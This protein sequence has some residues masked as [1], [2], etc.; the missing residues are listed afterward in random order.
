MQLFGL[1]CT[2]A[3]C[4]AALVV[5]VRL[6]LLAR[7]TRELP[8]LMIGCGFLTGAMIG[9]PAGVA[10]G[11]LASESSALAL[12]VAAAGSIGLGLSTVF[13]LV[14]WWKIYHPASRWGPW[15]V[16]IWSVLVAAVVVAELGRSVAELA[17]GANPWDP[18]RLIVEGG[19]FLAMVCSGFRYYALLRRRMRVGLADPVVANRILLW[20]LAA[21]GVTLQCGYMLAL[22]Y[23]NLIFDADRVAPVF[24]GLLGLFIAVCITYAFYPPQAYLDRIRRR[25]GLEV[26]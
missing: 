16:S 15:V 10:A 3:Y 6:V 13:V 14:A 2:V 8:E 23:L 21:S 17:P 25:A 19:A 9:Y 18:H 5:G 22:P 12:T 24:Y 26:S 4:V 20:N 7:R 11:L 1:L